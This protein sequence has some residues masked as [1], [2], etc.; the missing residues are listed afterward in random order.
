MSGEAASSPLAQAPGSETE[1]E[2]RLSRPTPALLEALAGVRGDILVLGAGGKMGPSLTAM[3]QRAAHELGDG[4]QVIALSRWSDVTV[5]DRL[6]ALGVR[7]LT[8][9]LTSRDS[10]DALP[11]AQNV[12]FMAGQKFGTRDAPHATWMAN[13]IVPFLAAERYRT[14]RIVA[15]STGNVY[16]LSPVT[17]SGSREDEAPAPVGEYAASCLG[18]ERVFEYA[19]HTWSTPVA[20]MR[21]N[22]A[23]DLRYGVL[24]DLAEQILRGQPI[25]LAMGFA[26]C[27]WQGDANAAALGL[28][29]HAQHPPLVL[30]VTG[31]ERLSVREVALE[32]GRRLGRAPTF[33]GAEAPD[34]LLSDTRRMVALL[35]TPAVDTPTLVAWVCEWLLRGG[36]TLGKATRFE[37]RDGA[38]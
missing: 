16:G 1:L 36:R 34:A 29:A 19:A 12:V 3:A 10:I 25:D 30:N 17:G 38:F 28:L 8:G 21:L 15:F 23:V 2:E 4:R 11:D 20:I 13:T 7:I 27:I 22:Y 37:R 9:D 24:V 6:A 14:S 5:R 32:L 31:V 35:G 18:R 33:T 26:N